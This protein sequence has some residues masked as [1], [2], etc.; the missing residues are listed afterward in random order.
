MDDEHALNTDMHLQTN[1]RCEICGK[2]C[3]TESDLTYHLKKHEVVKNVHSQEVQTC[4]YFL[5]GYCSFDSNECWFNHPDLSKVDPVPRTLT[6]VKCR[7]CE[8]SFQTKSEF[9]EHR[10]LE[11]FQ[12][13][14]SCKKEMDGFCRF[15]DEKCWYAH[16]Y[17]FQSK[18]TE[19]LNED[20]EL[21]N[22]LFTMMEKFTK[23][24]ENIEN[25]L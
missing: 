5:D 21:I 19:N 15:G 6:S 17:S 24:I 8:Q 3:R 23:R 7:F 11:H 20:P 9:M 12:K 25:Q 13:I 1:F 2:W 14:S 4:P 22:R 18:K 16:K 10:K